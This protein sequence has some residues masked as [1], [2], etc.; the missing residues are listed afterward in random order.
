MGTHTVK[1]V[2]MLDHESELAVRSAGSVVISVPS[3]NIDGPVVVQA[4][5][6]LWSSAGFETNRVVTSLPPESVY[7][8]WLHLEAGSEAELDEVARST[9]SRGAP[10]PPSDA[11]VDYRVLSSRPAGR[12]VLYSLML[13]TASSSAVDRVMNVAE[14]AGLEVVAVDVGI[15]AVSRSLNTQKN[16]GNPLWTGQPRSHCVLGAKNTLVSVVRGGLLEFSR[17]VPIGGNDFTQMLAQTLEIE[18]SVAERLKIDRSARLDE[19]GVLVASHASTEVLVPCEALMDRLAREIQRSLR[20]F[21]SQYAEGS[22]LGTIG[23][24]TL[25]GGGANLRGI[26]SCLKSYGVDVSGIINPFA[27]YA[28]EAGGAGIRHVGE[29]SASYTTAVGLAVGVYDRMSVQ[30]TALAA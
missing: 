12:G 7:L 1:G 24:V 5:R 22:Y 11:I 30:G 25:S 23:T 17:A 9:A 28:V 8:K 15:A 13:V 27:G 21:S 20:Y 18:T 4:I 3:E 29:D 19:G 14:K 16:H 26:D 2:E 10:F 6:A